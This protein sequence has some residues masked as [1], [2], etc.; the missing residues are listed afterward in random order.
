MLAVAP[1]IRRVTA[2]D[3]PALTRVLARAYSDDPVAVWA[4]RSDALRPVVL[5]RLYA[6]RLRQALIHREIW[7]TV[8]LSSVAVWVPSDDGRAGLAREAVLARHFLH[9]RLAARAPLLA[10]G[11]ITIKRRRPRASRHWYL[12]LLGTDPV[13]QGQGLGSAVLQPVLERSDAEGIGIYLE[14]SKERNL[15]F[16]AR[17]GFRMTN[18]FRLPRGPLMWAMWRE[19]AGER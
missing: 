3:V 16:Y 8:E 10:A 12:S 14:S 6:A 9:P 13:A 7:T 5:E 4:C 18:A 15:G 19:P 11:V 17:H 1:T 2:A